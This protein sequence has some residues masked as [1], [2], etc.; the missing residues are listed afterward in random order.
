MSKQVHRVL[1]WYYLVA[2]NMERRSM[3]QN[4]LPGQAP[5]FAE[6]KSCIF[7]EQPNTVIS[8]ERCQNNMFLSL[9][10]ATLDHGMY[11]MGQLSSVLWS[12][13]AASVL[14]VGI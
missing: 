12:T 3:L 7:Q 1:A 8:G 10:P 13:L 11:N 2:V 5:V 6:S 4:P 9:C 14:T